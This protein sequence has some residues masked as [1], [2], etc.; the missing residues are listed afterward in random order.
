M[1]WILARWL[2]AAALALLVGAT[3][4]ATVLA[5]R[6]ARRGT[7]DAA[8]AADAARLALGATLA[9]VPASVLRLTDQLVALQSPGDAP[10]TGLGALL[11]ATTWGTGFVLQTVLHA[12]AAGAAWW[13]VRRPTS[14]SAWGMLTAAAALLCATPALQGHA[15]ATEGR[16]GWAVAGHTLHVLGASA[17]IGTL[18]AIGW[19]VLAVRRDGASADDPAFAVERARRDARLRAL[20]PLLAPV[21]LAGAALLLVGG[22]AGA[23]LHLTAVA[24]LWATPWGRYLAAKGGLATVVLA[25]GALNWRRLVPRVDAGAPVQPLRRSIAAELTVAA[26]VLLV[27]AILV[28]TPP[29]GE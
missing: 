10:W 12:I 5:P 26:L 17:W 2:S 21:A 22:V 4:V 16:E 19:L 15:I 27:T 14:R 1:E 28:I 9:L 7:G 25:L 6:L 11:G 13:A 23:V 3:L 24:D 20:A 18:T 29:P 8:L